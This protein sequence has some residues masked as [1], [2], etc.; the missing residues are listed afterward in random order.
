MNVLGIMAGVA[1][2]WGVILQWEVRRRTREL[3]DTRDVL[4]STIDALPDPLIELSEQGEIL[5]VH[6]DHSDLFTRSADKQVNRH[7]SQ[8]LSEQAASV[9][10][11]ALAEAG[12]KGLSRG[13][14]IEVSLPTGLAWIEL[15]ISRRSLNAQGETRFLMLNLNI[16][17]R[18]H[19]EQRIHRLKRLYTTLSRSNQAIT[20]VND[21]RALLR[22]ICNIAVSFAEMKVAWAGLFDPLGQKLR[23]V[24][25]A[26]EGTDFLYDL[27]VSTDPQG[28]GPLDRA[29]QEGR[30]QWCQDFLQEQ[31]LAPWHDR[32]RQYGWRSGAALPLHRGQE[33]IGALVLYHPEVN[34]FDAESQSLLVEMVRDINLALERMSTQAQ[35]LRLESEVAASEKKYHELTGMIHDVIW[36]L[37]PE[38]L[39][40]LYVSPSVKRLRGYTPEEVIAE[41]FSVSMCPDSSHR[42]E[43]QIR[44]ELQEFKEGL[45]SSEIVSVDEVEQ[46]CKDGSTIWTEV[47]TNLIRNGSTGRIEV[48]GITRDITERRFAHEQMKRLVFSDRLTG[49]ANQLL[50]RDRF[51]N[52][53]ELAQK[54]GRRV[55][56]MTLDLD[57]FKDINDTLGHSVGDKVLVAVARRLIVQLR[58]GDTLSRPGSDEFVLLLPDTDAEGAMALVQRLLE[59]VSMPYQIDQEELFL[60]TS[61]GVAIYPD[62]GNTMETL[63]SSA[64]AAMHE[65]KQEARNGFRFSTPQLQDQISRKV[66]ISKALHLC[67]ER[68]EFKVLYQPQLDLKSNRIIGAEALLS[69]KSKELGPVSSAEFIPVAESNGLIIPI[70]DWV[71]RQ[72]VRDAQSWKLDPQQYQE[73]LTVS[74]NLSAVQF[75]SS[76]LS[77]RILEILR[78]EEFPPSC[79]ELEITESVMLKNPDEAMRVMDTLCAEGVQMAIDDFGTGYSSLSYLK[80]IPAHK[81]KIDQSFMRGLTTSRDDHAIVLT[82]INLAQTMQMHTIAEGVETQ[83]QME[84]LRQL[85]CEQVQGYFIGRPMTSGAFRDL[86]VQWPS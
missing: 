6:S 58:P 25:W 54:H 71:L 49:L 61:I 66:H 34:G 1:A 3:E 7:L 41:P 56:L 69:W 4:A 21:G 51:Q 35:K 38:T 42:M 9:I 53:L 64:D 20:R 19:S 13:R 57:H 17:A 74:V 10:M 11:E 86:T 23:A 45:R 60:T 15:S 82:I 5:T 27:Q 84:L 8:V 47:M 81:L 12:Q 33:V 83:E 73:P 26:G 16:T 30:P 32:A 85:G 37:D 46:T 52:A 14:E 36:T 43:E 22:E 76:N 48:H 40:Y 29:L 62:N 77:S 28:C 63:M 44:A 78:E 75:R 24:A 68:N 2:F 65:V 59:T 39:R 55:C 79:L 67:R 70:G 18:K 80:R 31:G 72:A 50:L